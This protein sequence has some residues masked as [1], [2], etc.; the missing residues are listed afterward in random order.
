MVVALHAVRRGQEMLVLVLPE[1]T[2]TFLRPLVDGPANRGLDVLPAL[3]E[4]QDLGVRPGAGIPERP[5]RD[6][7]ILWVR[8]RRLRGLHEALHRFVRLRQILDVG[9]DHA[10]V[11]HEKYGGA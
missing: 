10:P 11:M 8:L 7:R 3:V 1:G 2:R 5:L 4:G 9:R 6:A